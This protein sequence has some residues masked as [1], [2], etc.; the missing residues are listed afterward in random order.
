MDLEVLGSNFNDERKKFV[1]PIVMELKMK[2]YPTTRII[3]LL[4]SSKK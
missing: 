4:I 2:R 3:G 1:F